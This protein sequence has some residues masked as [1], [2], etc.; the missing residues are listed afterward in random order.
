MLELMLL[1]HAKS[2]WANIGQPDIDRPLNERGIRAAK[3]MG[4]YMETNALLPVRVLCSPARRALE[5]WERVAA[6]MKHPPVMIIDS[7]I[8][9]FGDG[10]ALMQVLRLKSGETKS[11][12][13][14]GHNPSIEGLANKLVGHGDDGLRKQLAKK[15]PTATLAV[16]TFDVD[17]WADV[18]EVAGTLKGFVR[19]RDI[20]TKDR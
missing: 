15:Y 17:G 14:V 6:E 8:Y 7:G 1:R 10:E 11:I 2:S 19:P 5:T 18:V 9:D 20:E 4:R 16:I 13:L 12:L 3:A